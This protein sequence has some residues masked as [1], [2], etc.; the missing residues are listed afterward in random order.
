MKIFDSVKTRLSLWLVGV[1]ALIIIVFSAG[2]YHILSKTLM[3]GTDAS[4]EAAAVN[5]RNDIMEGLEQT[6]FRHIAE[7]ELDDIRQMDEVKDI[8]F[9][10]YVQLL[11]LRTAGAGAQTEMKLTA[12]G[13]NLEDKT[14]PYPSS[15]VWK[16]PGAAYRSFTDPA[17][18]ETPLRMLTY[19]FSVS[20]ERYFILQ[21]AVTRT[22]AE[23][24]L[25]TLLTFM[26]VIDP[27][28]L[29]V[30]FWGG[31]FLVRRTLAPVKTV[32]ASARAIT[33]EDLSHRIPGAGSPDEIGE[34]TATFN[35]MIA[36]LEAAFQRIKQFS[37]DV[38][39]E[40]KSPLTVIRGEIDVLLRKDRSKEEYARTLAGVRDEVI[41]LQR[42]IDNLLF[43]AGTEGEGRKLHLEPVSLDKLVLETFETIQP[44][45]GEKHIRFVLH[46][47]PPAT[48]TGEETLLKR[49]LF[50]LMENAVKYTGEGGTVEL[51][52]ETE[53]DA[54]RFSVRDTGIGI[55]KADLLHIF[56]RFYRVDRSRTRKSGS[57][58]LGLAIAQ[59][60]VRLH[61]GEI[62]AVSTPGE[63][64]TFTVRL[65]RESRSKGVEG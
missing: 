31:Y 29:I 38:S 40:F 58:G 34:L 37:G 13:E 20:E 27:L 60:I 55:P 8:F 5:R 33:A 12:K 63:G 18:A 44:K 24:V 10:V 22:E 2:S 61:K 36:R 50:N 43:L 49:V 62:S 46:Q 51:R 41:S 14:L 48:V 30:L 4:L 32:A 3:N 59:R 7:D 64:S 28:L 56:S 15:G 26:L 19:T 21:Y 25:R 53:A 39:H 52:L 65:P 17:L 54:V 47:M 57:V 42:I 35:D 1:P 9:L 23:A 11:E 6:G 16:H 45:A